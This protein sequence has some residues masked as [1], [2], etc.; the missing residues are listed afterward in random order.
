MRSFSESNSTFEWQTG[1]RD[2]MSVEL[3][4]ILCGLVASKFVSKHCTGLCECIA[5]EQTTLSIHCELLLTS[6]NK[7]YLAFVWRLLPCQR[8]TKTYM[9]EHLLRMYWQDI[10]KDWRFLVVDS[11][12]SIILSVQHPGPRGRLNNRA[13][14]IPICHDGTGVFTI[15]PCPPPFGP[16]TE[17]VA[18]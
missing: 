14:P 7:Y 15:G 13:T 1:Q 12:L 10:C 6:N 18:N 9:L 16:S 17:N 5:P 2:D 8:I 4:V 11:R 3:F